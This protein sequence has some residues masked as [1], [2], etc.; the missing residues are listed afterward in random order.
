MVGG[1]ESFLREEPFENG[2]GGEKVTRWHSRQRKRPVWR[3][4]WLGGERPG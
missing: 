3:P 2:L 1:R 4:A